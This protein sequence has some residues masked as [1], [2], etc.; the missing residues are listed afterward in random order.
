MISTVPP[1]TVHWEGTALKPSVSVSKLSENRTIGA[2]MLVPALAS[3][4]DATM[5]SFFITTLSQTPSDVLLIHISV[6]FKL[7]NTLGAPA[8][9]QNPPSDVN[10]HQQGPCASTLRLVEVEIVFS[11]PTGARGPIAQR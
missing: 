1:A 9:S 8:Q 4:N 3:T 2:A 6:F 11:M 10:L 7:S 5:N